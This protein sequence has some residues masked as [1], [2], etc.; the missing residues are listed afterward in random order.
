MD[1]TVREELTKLLKKLKET[2]D[3]DRLTGREE[4]LGALSFKTHRRMFERVIDPFKVLAD[5]DLTVL[6]DDTA[7]QLTRKVEEAIQLFREVAEFELPDDGDAQ[8]QRESL[9]LRFNSTFGHDFFMLA[10]VTTLLVKQTEEVVAAAQRRMR[11]LVM[12]AEK[13]VR[14]TRQSRVLA[15]EARKQTQDAALKQGVATQGDY[16]DLAATEHATARGRWL[17][18]SVLLGGLMACLSGWLAMAY[19]RDWIQTP[20]LSQAAGVQIALAKAM[21]FSVL[22]TAFAWSLRVYRAEAHNHVVNQHRRNA[23]RTFRA[24]MVAAENP[25]V[26]EAVLLEATSCAFGQQPTGFSQ[27]EASDRRAGSLMGVV[28]AAGSAAR[29]SG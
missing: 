25:A 1:D 10:G 11:S 27:Q 16:F 24:F 17:F 14:E 22:F 3:I 23:L 19:M 28:R 12:Q 29:P 18:S 15:D 9:I 8:G 21:F 4:E 2:V 13:A 26:K 6:P 5:A 20:E 7:Q